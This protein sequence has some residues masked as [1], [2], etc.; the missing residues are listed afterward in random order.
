MTTFSEDIVESNFLVNIIESIHY[1]TKHNCEII[2][3]TISGQIIVKNNGKK[4]RIWDIDIELSNLENTNLSEKKIHIHELN[5]QEDWTKNYEVKITQEDEPPVLL[6]ESFLVH[7]KED[8]LYL[9]FEI[10]MENTSNF[11]ANNIKLIKSFPK[12]FILMSI[13][14]DNK[15]NTSTSNA[16]GVDSIV[17]DIEELK[18]S[19][20]SKLIITGSIDTKEYEVI[21]SGKIR[22]EY[23][24]VHGT[25]SGL[26][27]DFIDGLSEEVYYVDRDERDNEQNMWDCQFTFENKSEFPMKLIKFAF[28]SGAEDT[29]NENIENKDTEYKVFAQ[30]PNSIVNPGKKWISVLWDLGSKDIPT[31]NENVFYTVYPQIEEKLLMRMN[32]QPFMINLKDMIEEVEV[33]YQT[34]LKLV[35]EEKYEEAISKLEKVL[36]I[37]PTHIDALFEIGIAHGE[38]QNYKKAIEYFEKVLRIDP[39]NFSAWFGKGYTLYVDE[40]PKKALESYQKALEIDSENPLT[41]YFMGLTYYDLENDSKA[42]ECFR[43]NIEIEPMDPEPWNGIGLVYRDQRKYEEALEHFLIATELG[44]KEYAAKY[45]EEIPKKYKKKRDKLKPKIDKIVS[46]LKIKSR[47]LKIERD[48]IYIIEFLNKHGRPPT[49]DEIFIDLNLDFDLIPDIRRFINE[50][51]TYDSIKDKVSDLDFI[52]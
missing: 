7:E 13:K 43:K 48:S 16:G 29:E 10:K 42:L 38:L 46:E 21:P 24:L 5:P 31:F 6:K 12:E 2:E 37:D 25:Y 32:I 40:N 52:F 45:I 44:D 8:A 3:S 26:S 23:E 11:S 19:E 50:Q 18:S 35:E 33:L 27:I 51:I 47:Q 49:K 9:D 15:G 17:W 1:I 4:D 36:K 22:L 41:L 30:E 34:A 39:S 20:T 28:I 14:E